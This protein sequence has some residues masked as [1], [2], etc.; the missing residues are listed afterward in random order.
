[1]GKNGEAIE[2]YLMAL[3]LDPSIEFARKGLEKLR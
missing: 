3:Q 1:M 2:Y